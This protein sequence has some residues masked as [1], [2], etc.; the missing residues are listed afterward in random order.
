MNAIYFSNEFPKEDL[1]DV[2][3]QLHKESKSSIHHLLARFMSEA[4]RAVKKEIEQLPSSLKQIIP[5]FETL[6]AWAEQ[7]ELREGELCGAIDG[8]LL[9][10]LQ[11]SVYIW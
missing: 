7:K 3:R 1:K 6:S 5:P 4:T 9:V 10:L 2:F 8:V 11:I